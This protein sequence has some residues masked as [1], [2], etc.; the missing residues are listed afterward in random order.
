MGTRSIIAIPE[1]KTGFRGRYCHW[2]GYPQ[3]VGHALRSIVLRD[4]M[5]EAI[6]TLI[7]DNYGWSTVNAGAKQA[8][9]T[10]NDDGRFVPVPGYG[11]AYTTKDGQSSPDSWLTRKEESWCEWAYVL[12]S[13]RIDVYRATRDKW[14]KCA[15]YT[16]RFPELPMESLHSLDTEDL[17]VLT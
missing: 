9:D 7:I 2:D 3:G 17:L 5:E 10:T 14:V 13:D 8:L 1:G 11:I 6:R 15:N 4:G 16:I 12:H